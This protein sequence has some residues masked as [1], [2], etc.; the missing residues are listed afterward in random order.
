MNTSMLYVTILTQNQNDSINSIL[1]YGRVDGKDCCVVFSASG[2]L[3]LILCPKK[4]KGK[5]ATTYL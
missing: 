2:F 1:L 5:V 4:C 3:Y